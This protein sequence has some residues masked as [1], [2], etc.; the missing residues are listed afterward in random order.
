M[1]LIGRPNGSCRN[2]KHGGCAGDAERRRVLPHLRH[3]PDCRAEWRAQRRL[4]QVVQQRPLLP[5]A[6]EPD[7]EAGWQRLRGRLGA[8]DPRQVPAAA[9]P[10]RAPQRLALLLAAAVVV[11]ATALVVLGWPR[12][13]APDA[14]FRTLAQPEPAAAAARL[15]VVPSPTLPMADWQALLQAEGL[16]VV[17]GPNQAGAWRLAPVADDAASATADA[18]TLAR[19]RRTPGI[20]LAEPVAR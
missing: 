2:A 12:G 1:S 3:C 5:A 18:V 11:Q 13:T 15:T 7:A 16:R 20:V 19:L 17:D 4:Q 10:A 6:A 14:G 9:A 8:Q